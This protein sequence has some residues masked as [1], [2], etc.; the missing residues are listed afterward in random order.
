MKPLDQ[1]LSALGD[2]GPT[3]S[4]SSYAGSIA[5]TSRAGMQVVA[6]Q[7]TD[8]QVSVTYEE[9]LH[10]PAVRSAARPRVHD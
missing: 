1:M 4:V 6:A 3:V 10:V 2:L 5:L 8:G 7:E 9:A